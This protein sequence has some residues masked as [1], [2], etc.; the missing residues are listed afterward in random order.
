MA[1]EFTLEQQQA[2]AIAEAERA[3]AESKDSASWSD[4]L[5]QAPAKAGAAVVDEILNLPRNVYNIGQAAA[6][7]GNAAFGPGNVNVYGGQIAPETGQMTTPNDT[8]KD[9]LTEQNFIDPSLRNRMSPEQKM[10]DTAIQAGVGGLAGGTLRQAGVAAASG[11]LG[12]GVTEAT[13]SEEA[14]LLTTL[15]APLGGSKIKALNVERD[16]ARARNATRDETLQ[17][18]RDLGMVVVP[19]GKV[20]NFAGRPEMIKTALEINQ[21][22]TNEVAL[23]ALGLPPQVKAL[24]LNVLEQY[25]KDQYN[26]GYAPLKGLGTFTTSNDYVSNLLDIIDK[27]DNK[28]FGGAIPDAVNKLINRVNTPSF[29]A[30]DALKEIRELRSAAS[31]NLASDKPKRLTLGA[32]QKDLASA[33]EDEL[34]RAAI[35]AGAP[36]ELIANYRAARKQIAIAHTIDSAMK[37]ATGNVDLY[38]L[39]KMYDRGDYMEGDLLKAA[40]F[41]S[42][43]KPVGEPA[44]QN[45]PFQHYAGASLAYGASVSMGLPPGIGPA[46]LAVAGGLVGHQGREAVAGALRKGMMSDEGQRMLAPNYDSLG[47][48][49][50]SGALGGLMFEGANGSL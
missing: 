4:V 17:G 18:A 31:L 7:L 20:A 41:G 29:S 28:S 14:G 6:E 42:L 1:N 24:S 47:I 38:K 32:A 11:L 46:A 36:P 49:P 2:I 3:K 21:L 45:I 26:A 22:R 27:Y 35:N 34:E 30:E 10:A 44:N 12:Q 50:R 5:K 40:K 9:Y 39:G 16:A 8:V 25:K 33:I 19:E 37:G 15:L 43:G 48:D 13:G 23:R